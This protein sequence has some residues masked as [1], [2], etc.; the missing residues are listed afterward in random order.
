MSKR[1]AHGKEEGVWEREARNSFTALC[2]SRLAASCY[3][4]SRA[5]YKGPTGQLD[6]LPFQNEETG[7]QAWAGYNVRTRAQL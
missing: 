2:C 3:F 6:L 1:S 7:A 4:V 5:V